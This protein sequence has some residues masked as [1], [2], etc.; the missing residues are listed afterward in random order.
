M[1]RLPTICRNR[2]LET[3]DPDDLALLEP[4]FE[5][6]DLR[7]GAALFEPGQDVNHIYF[8]ERP[9]VVAMVVDL[10]EGDSAEATMI[11]WEG[12]VGGVVSAGSK[13]A[14]ARM[15]VQSSGPAVRLPIETLEQVKQESSSCRDHFSRYADCLLAQVMQ[16]VACN[17]THELDARLARW[18]LALN[19]RVGVPEMKLTQESAAQML[20][21][22]RTYVTKVLGQLERLGAIHRQR[23]K[24]IVRSRQRLSDHAC[25]CYGELRRHFDQ[26]LPGVYSP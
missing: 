14:F 22:R 15:V 9:A 10:S 8:L 20:G 2:L 3:L 21:V 16:T 17:T 26:I 7:A 24:V 13:P 11:G 23:G 6:V 19:D 5:R 25:E 1:N 12:A 4:R 18:L